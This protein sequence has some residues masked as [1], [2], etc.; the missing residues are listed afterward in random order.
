M[1]AFSRPDG[2]PPPPH[3]SQLET[4]EHCLDDDM[5][6]DYSLKSLV[7]GLFH[8]DK[9]FGLKASLFSEVPS[10]FL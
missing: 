4:E 1:G 7:T 5:A 2:P 6:T 8:R 9:L 10:G 3:H